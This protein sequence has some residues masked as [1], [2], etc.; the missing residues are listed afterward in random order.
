ME[1]MGTSYPKQEKPFRTDSVGTVGEFLS[2]NNRKSVPG[3]SV[4]MVIV[5]G[6]AMF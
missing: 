3:R 6:R 5:V 2:E 4:N 1:I